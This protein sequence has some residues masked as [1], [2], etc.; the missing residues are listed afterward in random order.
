MVNNWDLTRTSISQ[1]NLKLRFVIGA[2]IITVFIRSIILFAKSRL[3]FLFGDFNAVD[4][5]AHSRD[6][7][8]MTWKKQTKFNFIVVL[9]L[10]FI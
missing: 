2:F 3:A 10:L 1:L 7:A 6:N 5:Y 4:V 9:P 8:F